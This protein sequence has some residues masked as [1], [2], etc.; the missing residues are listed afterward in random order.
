MSEEM[1]IG[2]TDNNGSILHCAGTRTVKVASLHVR[3]YILY[4]CLL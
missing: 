4:S 1:V 2:A 3:S